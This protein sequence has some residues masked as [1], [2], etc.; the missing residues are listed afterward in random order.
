MIIRSLSLAP[1]FSNTILFSSLCV[2]LS[3]YSGRVCLPCPTISEWRTSTSVDS[4]FGLA[5]SS[6]VEFLHLRSPL[7]PTR[8][9][10]HS[11]GNS[12]FAFSQGAEF[13]HSFCSES[14]VAISAPMSSTK[15]ESTFQVQAQQ[16]QSDGT[17]NLEETY[18]SGM[19]LAVL[20]V[21]LMV[22][23]FLVALDMV[24]F[25]VPLQSNCSLIMYLRLLLPPPYPISHETSTA[26]TTLVG[27]DPPSFL[28]SQVSL[29]YGAKRT[30]VWP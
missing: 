7:C 12:P 1:A 28:P 22:S 16:D 24:S 26:L 10:R 29:S 27:M 6:R 8:R 23:I 4:P 5:L 9:Q 18:P 20:I 19:R 25:G 17:T 11:W 14:R 3:L 15:A 30:R 2:F 13:C 21:A